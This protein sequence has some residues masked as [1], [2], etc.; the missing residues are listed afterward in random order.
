MSDGTETA[1]AGVQAGTAT[2]PHRVAPHKLHED[3]Q[4]FAVGTSI[5]A[6]GLLMLTH[7]GLITGQTAG[8]A[9]LISYV[10]GWSFGAVFFVVNLPFYWLAWTRMGPR[11]TIKTFIAVAMLSVISEVLPHYVVFDT[12]SPPVAA[13]LAGA[14]SGFGLV[15]L[16]RHGASLGGLGVAALYLQDRTGFRA[17]WTQLIFDAGLFSVAFF[18]LPWEMVVWSLLGAVVVN[19]IVGVNHRRD[20]YL[21]T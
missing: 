20:R 17:G 12:L 4:A 19:L 18:V 5:M 15:V 13:L 2:E 8:L 3:V 21:G 16:F 11:F 9:V 6:F 1:G 14:V 10:T 7:V